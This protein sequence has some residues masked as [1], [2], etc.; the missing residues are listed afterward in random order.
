MIEAV[1]DLSVRPVILDSSVAIGL[2][3]IGQFG[4]LR[5]VFGKVAVT[6]TVYHEVQAGR[7]AGSIR[8]QCRNRGWLD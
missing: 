3:K 1:N 7:F 2:S 4:L 8:A 5:Q 6:E